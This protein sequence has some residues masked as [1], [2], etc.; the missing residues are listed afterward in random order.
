MCAPRR[1][2]GCSTRATTMPET[3]TTVTMDSDVVID[4]MRSSRG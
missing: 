4:I 1:R 3:A 2:G